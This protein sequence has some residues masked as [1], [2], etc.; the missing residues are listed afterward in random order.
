[1]ERLVNYWSSL[2]NYVDRVLFVKCN[3][4]RS[5]NDI[6]EK[7]NVEATPT[8]LFIKNNEQVASPY[9]ALNPGATAQIMATING[10]INSKEQ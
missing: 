10:L 9:T 7:Y 5:K 3:K 1:M 6:F 2:A 8:F 4:E